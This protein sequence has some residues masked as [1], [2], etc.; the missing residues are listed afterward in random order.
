MRAEQRNHVRNGITE[1]LRESGKNGIQMV[2]RPAKL[3]TKKG[4]HGASWNGMTQ[5]FS[6]G[7]T[8]DPHPR[9]S[10]NYENF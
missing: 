3:A 4:A 7:W 2:T 10:D 1:S 9:L 8:G 6:L 5:G